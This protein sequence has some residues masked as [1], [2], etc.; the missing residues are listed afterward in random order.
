MTVDLEGNVYIVES[1]V[2]R[3]LK[4]TPAGVLTIIA[5]STQPGF[6]GDGGPA[7]LAQLDEPKG[8]EVDEDGNVYFA[9]SEN[10]R[11]RKLTPDR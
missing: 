8:I 5:G 7:T 10:N 3:I 2:G 6:S 4:V 1:T 9:D 11:I